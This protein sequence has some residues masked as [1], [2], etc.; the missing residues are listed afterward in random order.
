M[1]SRFESPLDVNVHNGVVDACG[2]IDWAG[3]EDEAVVTVTI[4]QRK[5]KAVGS[6]HSTK[7]VPKPDTMWEVD[8]EALPGMQQLKP[9]PARASGVICGLGS[10]IEMREF[11]WTQDI[12]LK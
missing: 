6:G 10:G 12:E 5:G 2:P 11:T 1:H 8:V 3:D 9:G 4:S 7:A